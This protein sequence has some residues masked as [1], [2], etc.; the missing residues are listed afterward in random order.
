MR[1]M[2]VLGGIS[3]QAT[4]DFEVRVH[5][6]AQRLVPQDWNRGYPPMIV[7]YHRDLPILRGPD[8]RPS[9]PRQVDPALVEA[10]AQLGTIVDFLAIPCNAA[11]V[12]L[13]QIREA[14]DCLVLSMIE[15]AVEEIVRRKCRRVGV[16]GA[17]GVPPPY[18]EALGARGIAYEGIDASLQPRLDAAIRAVMEGRDGKEHTEMA[19]EAVGI[20]RARGVDAVLL[21]CTEIPLLL[22]DDTEASDLVHPAALLAEAA[23]RFAIEA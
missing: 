11:H 18:I 9:E 12:A 3:A 20:L 15:V 6:S 14:V 10:A 13:R 2:G 7:W 1:R 8:G 4:M 19:R 17:N 21:G 16:L 23:V 22:G 5:R